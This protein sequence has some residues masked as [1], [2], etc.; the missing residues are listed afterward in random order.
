MES[1]AALQFPPP[2]AAQNLG[3]VPT[4]VALSAA[5]SAAASFLACVLHLFQE[6]SFRPYWT[7]F[8]DDLRLCVMF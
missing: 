5:G 7:V 3:R 2:Q 6:H 4:P 8:L 1:V